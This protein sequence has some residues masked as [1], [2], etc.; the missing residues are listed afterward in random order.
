M[1]KKQEIKRDFWLYFWIFLVCSIIGT[2]Y[3]ETLYVI[4]YFF[5]HHRLGW[6]RRSGVIFG[7][8]S[9][10]YGFGAVVF[11]LLLGKKEEGKFKLFLKSSILGGILE[12]TLS[13]IQEITT[14]TTSWDYHGKFMNIGGRTSIPY[15]LIWGIAGVILIKC[16]Y[17][18][19]KGL[20]EC[21]SKNAYNLVSITLAVFISLDLLVTWTILGRMNLRDKGVEP[22]TVIGRLCDAYFPDTYIKKKFPNME[23]QD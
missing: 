7:P 17:P 9:P 19:I 13:L 11:V 8:I 1:K 5:K 12:F 10:V 23:E 18:L 3:E 21:L 16:I 6:S 20:L 4:R 2:Y 15:M 22:I 14:G